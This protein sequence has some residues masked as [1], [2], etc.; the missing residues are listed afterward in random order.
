MEVISSK[1]VVECLPYGE[2]YAYLL[3][4]SQCGAFGETVEEALE[5]LEFQEEE[6]FNEVASVYGLED[7]A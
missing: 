2:Y 1:Y 4:Y 7:M 3:N 5:N 6:F